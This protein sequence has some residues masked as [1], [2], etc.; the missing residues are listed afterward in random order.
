MV[1]GMEFDRVDA[2]AMA[3]VGAQA[4]PVAIG[5]EAQPIEFIAGQ[6]TVSREPRCEGGSALARDRLAQ[7]Q[8]V[9]PQVARLERRRLVVDPMRFER[10]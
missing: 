10:R 3:V 2:P 5:V 6:C 9:R 8:V 4:R 1:G 7:R